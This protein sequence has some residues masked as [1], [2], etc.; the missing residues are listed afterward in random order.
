ATCCILSDSVAFTLKIDL[1]SRSPFCGDKQG[2]STAPSYWQDFKTALDIAPDNLLHSILQDAKPLP[3][4]PV[5]DAYNYELLGRFFDIH[6]KRLLN[7]YR[8]NATRFKGYCL[9]VSSKQLLVAAKTAKSR[10][11]HYG[12]L[13]EFLNGT[14]AEISVVH[15]MLFD[16]KAVMV[17]AALLARESD[18]AKTVYEAF[19]ERSTLLMQVPWYERQKP[20]VSVPGY[21]EPQTLE[22]YSSPAQRAHQQAFGEHQSRRCAK[23][24]EAGNIIEEYVSA[25]EA[26]RANGISLVYM[27]KLCNGVRRSNKYRFKYL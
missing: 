15:N 5:F 7:A 16:D 10:G 23:L 14:V 13:C 1:S 17:F 27:Y 2:K 12:Y 24:D 6:E 21:I 4:I 26:A 19:K 20:Q 8:T 22:Q 18:I 9:D 11:S 3:Y 25:T